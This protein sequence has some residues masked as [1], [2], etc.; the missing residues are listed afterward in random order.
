MHFTCYCLCKWGR[1]EAED[2]GDLKK[3]EI[4]GWDRKNANWT[5]YGK[6]YYFGMNT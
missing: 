2:G 1:K 5:E 3:I 4:W 6:E